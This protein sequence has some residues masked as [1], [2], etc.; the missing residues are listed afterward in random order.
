MIELEAK[1]NTFI[2]FKY[3]STSSKCRIRK[4]YEAM[5]CLPAIVSY[6]FIKKENFI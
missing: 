4:K 3:T 5:H 6:F 2:E 1:H